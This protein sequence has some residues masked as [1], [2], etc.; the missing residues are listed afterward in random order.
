[1]L[2]LVALNNP[3][4]ITILVWINPSI[5]NPVLTIL[6]CYVAIRGVDNCFQI[7]VICF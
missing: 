3:K 4:K 2:M 7:H 1:M 6:E 5:C